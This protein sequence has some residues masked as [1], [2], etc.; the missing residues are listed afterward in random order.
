MIEA[1]AKALLRTAASRGVLF[2]ALAMVLAIVLSGAG[3]A[4][5][6]GNEPNWPEACKDKIA[7][8]ELQAT[9]SEQDRERANQLQ[10]SLAACRPQQTQDNPATAPEPTRATLPSL[11]DDLDGLI[12]ELDGALR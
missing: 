1:L 7:T 10:Q 5:T 9:R 8:L 4:Q 11:I 2:A 6:A 3:W 12:T